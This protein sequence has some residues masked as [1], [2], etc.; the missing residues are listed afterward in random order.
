MLTRLL[1]VTTVPN[2]LTKF[3]AEEVIVR[4]REFPPPPLSLSVFRDYRIAI[5]DDVAD[6]LSGLAGVRKG[7]AR[8]ETRDNNEMGAFR[9]L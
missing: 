3:S 2:P 1:C 5:N 9:R 6:V 7:N 8:E 4:D